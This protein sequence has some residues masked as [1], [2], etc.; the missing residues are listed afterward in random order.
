MST[1]LHPRAP[2][3]SD[4]ELRQALDELDAKIQTLRNRAHATAAGSPNTYQQHADALE[5]KRALLAQQLGES[6]AD[7]ADAGLLSQIRHGIESLRDDVRN[8]L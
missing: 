1:P 4:A 3:L 6:P 8:L 7:S 2:Q 5:T